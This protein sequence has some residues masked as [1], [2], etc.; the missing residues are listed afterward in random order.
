MKGLCTEMT[1]TSLQRLAERYACETALLRLGRELARK[2]WLERQLG[3][4]KG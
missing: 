2:L 4:L 3:P 1:K